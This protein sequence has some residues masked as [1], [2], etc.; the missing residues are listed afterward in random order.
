MV[1]TPPRLLLMVTIGRAILPP[2]L[3]AVK[4]DADELATAAPL[5]PATRPP[6]CTAA[7][8]SFLPLACPLTL[9]PAAL[10]FKR[11][12]E[13]TVEGAAVGPLISLVLGCTL[14]PADCLAAVS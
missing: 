6:F 11:G 14:L 3:A 13:L 5:D 7:D 8:R 4:D 10:P 12:S 1:V 2:P 9:P